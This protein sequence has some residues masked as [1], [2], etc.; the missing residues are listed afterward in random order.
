MDNP[1]DDSSWV[2]TGDTI[3]IQQTL[4]WDQFTLG[5][6]SIPIGHR[7]LGIK[8]LDP[9]QNDYLY[10]DDFGYNIQN[11]CQPAIT[12]AQALTPQTIA[13]SWSSIS[14]QASYELV[15]WKVDSFGFSGL[16]KLYTTG[17][18]DTLIG[19][20]PKSKYGILARTICSPG[21]T[22][23]YSPII[24]V[25]T[26]CLFVNQLPLFES[27][28]SVDWVTD[29]SSASSQNSVLDVCWTRS[30]LS[31][32]FGWFVREGSTASALTGPVSGFGGSGKYL[33]TEASL[34]STGNVSFLDVPIVN[35]DS[36]QY[37]FIKFNYHMYG[38]DM[39]SLIT[40]VNMNGTWISLDSISGAQQSAD[41]DPWKERTV[42]LIP[43]S[44]L[45]T[46]PIR[47]K[48]IRGAGFRGDISV[49]NFRVIDSIPS[50]ASPNG[51]MVKDTNC[52]SLILEFNS[53]GGVS[54]IEFGLSGFSPGTGSV[55]SAINSPIVLGGLL[56]G[57]NYDF[58]LS[59]ICGPD[60]SFPAKLIN[61]STL[62]GVPPI[63][64]FTFQV[65]PSNGGW[66]VSFAANTGQGYS[67]QWNFGNGSVGFGATDSV[68]YSTDGNYTVSLM[69]SNNCG[70]DTISQNVNIWLGQSESDF[71]HTLQLIPNPTS[72]RVAISYEFNAPLA[73]TIEILDARGVVIFRS[74]Q[75][76]KALNYKLLDISHWAAGVYFVKV[77]NEDGIATR[78][79]ILH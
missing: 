56:S 53:A 61:V 50:C 33:Y 14:T 54:M 22:S 65:Y 51:L 29:N 47:L 49:D 27:F 25:N 1:L 57:T 73:S 11:A 52:N 31:N 10:V 75:E 41:T 55:V 7:Y 28:N 30:N 46:L 72:G 43:F 58:Y 71:Q 40:Q 12:V 69:V 45:Q 68:L 16:S 3:T 70:F 38:Q 4:V 15:Y 77:S 62:Q 59:N 5:M 23:E 48:A 42:S 39:G 63:A 37:P 60:T 6:S 17:L 76:P 8:A 67:Y 34:G 79:L 21:D 20:L 35:L 9:L 19:L 13:V 78:Q 32:Q 74:Q 26:P 2:S 64:Y 18:A 36:S 66:L 24:Y 44:G